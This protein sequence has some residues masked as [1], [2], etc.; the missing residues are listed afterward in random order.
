[1]ISHLI[2]IH[3]PD[4]LFAA[5]FFFKNFEL[6][7]QNL[8]AGD[9]ETLVYYFLPPANPF[10]SRKSSKQIEM[11]LLHSWLFAWFKHDIYGSSNETAP[12]YYC[13]TAL[14]QK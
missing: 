10:L 11:Q 1:M 14:R 3:F 2:F 8:L 4:P 6:K 9:E 7:W 5:L 13:L 12:D